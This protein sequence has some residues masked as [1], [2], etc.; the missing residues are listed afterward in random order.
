MSLA[1]KRILCVDGNKDL[2]KLMEGFLKRVGFECKTAGSISEAL[3]LATGEKFD[4]YVLENTFA[5]G[6]GLELCE[7]LRE[8]DPVS[9]IIFYCVDPYEPT[10]QQALDAGAQERLFND[11]DINKLV[12]TI[13]RLL[14]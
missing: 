9:P 3:L 12:E 6:T 2:C 7:M 13:R 4:V 11:G 10:R 1:T 14:S 5:D 8:Y